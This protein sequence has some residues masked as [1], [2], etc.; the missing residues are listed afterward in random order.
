M[1]ENI[2]VILDPTIQADDQRVTI[3]R[4]D[5]IIKKVK[6]VRYTK[7]KRVKRKRMSKLELCFSKS[8]LN[9][10]RYV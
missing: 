1:D 8:P 9:P 3:P 2:V 4:K 5:H 10:M 6:N 7:P